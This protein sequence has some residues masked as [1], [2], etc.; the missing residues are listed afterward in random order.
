MAINRISKMARVRIGCRVPGQVL[1][2]GILFSGTEEQEFLIAESDLPGLMR[3]MESP[4]ELEQ[5]RWES[6]DRAL[7]EAEKAF[8]NRLSKD[9]K[10]RKYKDIEEAEKLTGLSVPSM[11]YSLHQRDLMPLTKVHI[12]ERGLLPPQKEDELSTSREL[13]KE[14]VAGLAELLRQQ[15]QQQAVSKGK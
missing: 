8:R 1:P 13:I 3:L 4:V 6:D 15:A 11:F 12:L 9:V 10:D 2:G 7:G 5:G 14:A